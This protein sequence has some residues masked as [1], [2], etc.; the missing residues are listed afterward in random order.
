[1]S[2]TGFLVVSTENEP[3]TCLEQ[4]LMRRTPCQKTLIKLYS[5]FSMSTSKLRSS[6]RRCAGTSDQWCGPA[7]FSL[8]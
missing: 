1:M 4:V 7:E 8:H 6:A 2:G 3:H 5:T